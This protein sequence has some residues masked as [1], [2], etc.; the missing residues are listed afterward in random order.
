MESIPSK[1]DGQLPDPRVSSFPDRFSSKIFSA[2]R[3]FRMDKMFTYEEYKMW[4]YGNAFDFESKEVED[5]IEEN[6]NK[7]L[8]LEFMFSFVPVEEE[9]T[10]I[11]DKVM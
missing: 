1:G 2:A 3:N 6:I 11:S 8:P 5:R 7:Q 10:F 4:H 9:M